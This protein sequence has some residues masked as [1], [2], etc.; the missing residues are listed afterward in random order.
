MPGPDGTGFYKDRQILFPETFRVHKTTF[1][2]PFFRLYEAEDCLRRGFGL[3]EESHVSRIF[4]PHDLRF[5]M[6]GDHL[7]GGFDGNVVVLA[8]EDEQYGDFRFAQHFV[9]GPCGR[10]CR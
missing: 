3:F 8:A 9:A 4:E 10:S 1:L 6:F 7:F 2:K 5:R